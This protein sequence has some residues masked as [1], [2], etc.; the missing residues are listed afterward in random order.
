MVISSIGLHVNFPP[1]FLPSYLGGVARFVRCQRRAR[2]AFQAWR[3]DE[4]IAP[5]PVPSLA[6]VIDNVARR[7]PMSQLDVRDLVQ[8]AGVAKLGPDRRDA[9][10]AR[11]RGAL[12][13]VVAP[14]DVEL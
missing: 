8:G 5:R 2:V 4:C 6:L 9:E 10:I 1:S 3:P 7:L 14:S 13:R 12:C 11:I